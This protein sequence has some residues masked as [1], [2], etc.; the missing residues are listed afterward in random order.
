[1]NSLLVRIIAV[2]LVL[3]V[4]AVIRRRNA[5]RKFLRSLQ[6]LTPI[7]IPERPPSWVQANH[8]TLLQQAQAELFK[9]P[10]GSDPIEDVQEAQNRYREGHIAV[11]AMS[12]NWEKIPEATQ[13]FLHC[14]KPLAFT[15]VAETIHALS[16][17]SG[18]RYVPSGIAAATEWTTE[19][20]K[21]D[22]QCPE[23]WIE[24][25]IILC[26]GLSRAHLLSAEMALAQ[27]QAIAP[28]HPRLP[29][30][31]FAIYT[32]RRQYAQ[33]EQAIRRSLAYADAGRFL[34]VER[35]ALLN[36]LAINLDV[37]RKAAEALAIYRRLTTDF[38]DYA[39]GW[40]NGSQA[41][42]RAGK[43]EEALQFSDR[44]IALMPFPLALQTNAKIRQRLAQVAHK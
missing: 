42:L 23:A 25:T 43:L 35:R 6:P 41:L 34:P 22:P 11:I 31:E 12:G 7:P 8:T 30:A 19:A 21:L 14:P 33:A 5:Q 1:M 36:S 16:Y 39:W 20:I 2:V 29:A 4:L 44:A 40:H 10:W 32:R 13:H 9:I 18:Y 15:G 24:R 38:P 3:S 27:S 37:Q 28:D 26:K 17:V